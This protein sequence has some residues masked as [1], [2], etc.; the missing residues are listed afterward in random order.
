MQNITW[1]FRQLLP[2]T[3]RSRYEWEGK[4][5]YSVFKMWFGHVYKH[6]QFEIAKEYKD[7]EEIA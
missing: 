7:Y 5:M 2:T 3:Y 1:Y 4:K 6:D